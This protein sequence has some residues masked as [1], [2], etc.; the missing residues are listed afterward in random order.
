[1]ITEQEMIAALEKAVEERGDKYIYPDKLKT[2]DGFCRYRLDDGTPGCIVGLAMS[3]LSP[4]TNLEEGKS[5][6][7]TL[8]Q[9]ADDYAIWVASR[10]QRK[11]DRG[12]TWGEALIEA[13]TPFPAP[14]E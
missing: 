8:A 14:A 11:Q 4:Q 1:M 5:V 12:H 3:Y 7:Y 2:H 6:F 13:K 10:A 9:V